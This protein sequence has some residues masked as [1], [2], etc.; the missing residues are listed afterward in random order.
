MNPLPSFLVSLALT[1]S[2]SCLASTFEV[3]GDQFHLDG[4]A[5]QIRSG[6]MHYPRIP[7]AE[8]D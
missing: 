4:Q 6:E 1:L 5:F 7:V 2:S 3:A 8:W